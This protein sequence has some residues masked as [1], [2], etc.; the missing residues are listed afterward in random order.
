ME[1]QSEDAWISTKDAEGPRRD[2][3]I[4]VLWKSLRHRPRGID[5]GHRSVLHK[6]QRQEYDEQIVLIWL[7]QMQIILQLQVH[8][9]ELNKL[10]EEWSV[11]I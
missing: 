1:E 8:T 9:S 4:L 3:Y 11:Y 2:S 7:F 10:H 6:P 5:Q